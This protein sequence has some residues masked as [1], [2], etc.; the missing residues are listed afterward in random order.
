MHHYLRPLLAPRSVALVGASQ[1]PGSLGRIVFEN[2]LAGEFKGA[3]YPVNPNHGRVLTHRTYASLAEIGQPIDLAIVATPA[4]TVP[5][6]L[7]RVP[8][9]GL[10]AAVLMSAPTRVDRTAANAWAR[11]VSAIARKRAVRLVGPGALGVIRTDIGLNG[12]FC[13]PA[14]RS[15]RRCSIS[16][17][18]WGWAS[19]R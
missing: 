7:E 19:R 13:A 6:I 17:R 5:G 10:G 11:A 3:L 16:R 14:A 4:D 8:K 2:L 1:R 9:G 15:A 18:R 12:T